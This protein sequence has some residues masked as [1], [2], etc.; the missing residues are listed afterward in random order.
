M[1]DIDVT[2]IVE[3]AKTFPPELQ[4]FQIVKA[5]VAAVRA[6]DAKISDAALA[7][8]FKQFWKG[9]VHPTVAASTYATTTHLAWG[10]HLLKRGQP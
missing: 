1:S 2:A 7:D 6:A 4:G 9:E 8:D 10:R 3:A 5:T